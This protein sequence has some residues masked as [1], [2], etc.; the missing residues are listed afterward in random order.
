VAAEAFYSKNG[1]STDWGMSSGASFT[2]Y[3]PEDEGRITGTASIWDW[4]INYT[5]DPDIN[6]QCGM[7]VMGPVLK[8]EADYKLLDELFS[9][10]DISRSID[11]NTRNSLK[12]AGITEDHY[13]LV[14]A[15]LV[16]ARRDSEYP[17]SIEVPSFEFTPTTEE[18][19]EVAKT[20]AIMKENALARK[21]NI[22]VYNRLRPE[23]DPIL[24]KLEQMMY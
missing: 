1:F 9:S 8:I 23:L 6:K 2:F 24:D 4:M 12:K 7:P 20:I 16:M 10:P 11:E 19:R 3:H 22:G 14:K 5:E 13:A 18:E 21:S 17:E 15:S